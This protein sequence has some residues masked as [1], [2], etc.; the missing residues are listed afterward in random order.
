M[1]ITDKEIWTARDVILDVV[2]N[3]QF[4][5][6]LDSC[7]MPGKY[8]P[9]RIG[10]AIRRLPESERELL[11]DLKSDDFKDVRPLSHCGPHPNK[12]TMRIFRIPHE[13]S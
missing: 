8:Y 7:H 1:K 12:S 3:R 13:K 9:G 4:D 10:E 2:D 11:K 6:C 5:F